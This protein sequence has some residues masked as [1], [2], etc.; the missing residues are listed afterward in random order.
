MRSTLLKALGPAMAVLLFPAMAMAD[1]IVGVWKTEP[2]R[3]NLISHI[4]I[5]ACG[6]NF[7]GNIQSAYDAAGK[8]VQTPN[9]GKKLFW[10]V[11]SEGDGKY[12]G[13]E[14]WVPLIDV[15]AVPQMT[16][17]GDQLLVKGCE[18]LVCAHQTWT[19]L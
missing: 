5:T 10:D 14:F 3:K 16:L 13:G 9:I 7:C 15:D 1:P 8:E 18:H 12:G 19:R 11:A 17:Q 2:D 6:E 4:K